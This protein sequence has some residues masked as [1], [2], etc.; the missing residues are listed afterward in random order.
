M[1]WI[2][3]QLDQKIQGMIP[4]HLLCKFHDDNLTVFRNSCRNTVYTHTSERQIGESH[5]RNLNMPAQLKFQC[6]YLMF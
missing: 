5:I 3:T 1:T 2:L 4:E 6:G